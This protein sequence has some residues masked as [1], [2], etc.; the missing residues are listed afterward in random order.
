MNLVSVKRRI[1]YFKKNDGLHNQK[2]TVNTSLKNYT[3]KC[4]LFVDIIMVICM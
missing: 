3:S 2:V 4:G 1:Y